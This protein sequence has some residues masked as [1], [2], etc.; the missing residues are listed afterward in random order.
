MCSRFVFSVILLF[1]ICLFRWCILVS[2][3]YNKSTIQRWQ[4]HIE[5]CRIW[6]RCLYVILWWEIMMWFTWLCTDS[7]IGHWTADLAGLNAQFIIY[8]II[9]L[10]HDPLN[11]SSIIC[12]SSG[13]HCIFAVSGILTLG[14]LPYIA[15][16][17]SRLNSTLWCT[18]RN[19]L[20]WLVCFW[21]DS[22]QVL[23]SL[24]WCHEIITTGYGGPRSYL[25]ITDCCIFECWHVL[26]N[27]SST[28]VTIFFL[29]T[30]TTEN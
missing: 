24:G 4:R 15:R 7:C 19:P 27:K 16:I 18:V 9:I 3:K 12:S 13:V 17:K 6:F 11:V 26:K 29:L 23:K 28:H 22:F 20:N 10:Y 8:S 25:M 14:M 30:W 21:V 2:E 1:H 5:F